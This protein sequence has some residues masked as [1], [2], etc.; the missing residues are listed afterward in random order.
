MKQL[1]TRALMVLGLIAFLLLGTAFFCGR[2]VADGSMWASSRVNSSAYS[3]SRL[4]R[5]A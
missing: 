5:G 1:R 3:S 2:Y 4:T